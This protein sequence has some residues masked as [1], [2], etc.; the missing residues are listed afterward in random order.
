ES[1]KII[2][3]IE[4]PA[5]KKIVSAFFSWISK[6]KE[7]ETKSAQFIK[8][9][10]EELIPLADQAYLLELGEMSNNKA[11][12][13]KELMQTRSDL[14]ALYLRRRMRDLATKMK[15]AKDEDSLTG[16]NEN[17]KSL[18]EQLK[19]LDQAVIK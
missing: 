4:N 1:E 15:E 5:T 9:L 10:A 11:L 17:F 19:K 18:K 6:L 16:L 2:A 8:S 14:Y 7:E 13:Q 12:F 3:V